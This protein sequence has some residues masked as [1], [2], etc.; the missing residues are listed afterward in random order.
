[1][2]ETPIQTFGDGIDHPTSRKTASLG[3]AAKAFFTSHLSQDTDKVTFQMGYSGEVAD[4]AYLTQSF[5]SF[6]A[7]FADMKL[8]VLIQ[9]GISFANAIANVAFNKQNKVSSKWW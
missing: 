3:D 6:Q 4:H 9:N 1:M 8:I 2:T 7:L 5:V